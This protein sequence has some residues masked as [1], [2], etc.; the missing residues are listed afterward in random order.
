MQVGMCTRSLVLKR[1][2]TKT[3]LGEEITLHT[4][5]PSELGVFS[6]MLR[7]IYPTTKVNESGWARSHQTMKSEIQPYQD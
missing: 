2:V 5:L 3:Y 4:I 6:F 1:H 7:P